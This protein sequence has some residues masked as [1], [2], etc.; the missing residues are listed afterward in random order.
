[1]KAPAFHQ[2][3][4]KEVGLC[5]PVARKQSTSG[6]HISMI[7]AEY[8]NSSRGHWPGVTRA[9]TIVFYFGGHAHLCCS[10]MKR[11]QILRDVASRPFKCFERLRGAST[12]K[13]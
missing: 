10:F 3:E 8:R 5:L 13:N 6:N 7:I 2:E 12:L 9:A 1:M 4:S 11:P